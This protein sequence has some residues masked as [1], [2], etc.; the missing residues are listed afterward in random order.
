MNEGFDQNSLSPDDLAILQAFDA[1]DL[2][3]MEAGEGEEEREEGK[4]PKDAPQPA[5]TPSSDQHALTPMLL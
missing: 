4:Q 2:G 3:N 5:R 1:M